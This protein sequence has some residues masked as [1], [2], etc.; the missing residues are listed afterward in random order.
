MLMVCFKHHSKITSTFSG[1]REENP[2]RLFQL[3]VVPLRPNQRPGLWWGGLMLHGSRIEAHPLSKQNL[4]EINYGKKLSPRKERQRE[5]SERNM[6]VYCFLLWGK[7]NTPTAKILNSFFN[8]PACERTM[9][10]KIQKNNQTFT[11]WND[12]SKWVGNK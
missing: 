4:K 11:A 8:L 9:I 10:R 6:R 12:V 1:N 2:Q 5:E 7:C 3:V